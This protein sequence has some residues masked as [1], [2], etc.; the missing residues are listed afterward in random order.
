MDSQKMFLLGYDF[1]INVEY[2]IDG[3]KSHNKK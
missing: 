1:Y 3:D 2:A